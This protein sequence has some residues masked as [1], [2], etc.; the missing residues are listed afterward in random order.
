M[1]PMFRLRRCPWAASVVVLLAGGASAETP[2][3]K[4]NGFEAADKLPQPQP[5][6]ALVTFE[7]EDTDLPEL[8]KV[9]SRMTGK[10]FM[11]AAPKAR[12]FKAS[13]HSP[14]KVTV[15][16]AYQAFLAILQANGL[17]VLNQGKFYKIVDT[18]DVTRQTTAMTRD[19]D[20]IP[21]EERYITH[22]HRLKHGHAEELATGVL[23]KFQSHDGSI[24][25]YG[26][27]NLLII[28]D[29]GANVRRMLRILDELDS[30]GAEDKLYF[31]PIHYV[32]ST[33]LEKKV[34]E[35]IDGRRGGSDPKE[36]PS[37]RLVAL[38]RPN[39]LVIV[40]S[41]ESYRRVLEIVK[42][43]DV[44]E[45]RDIQVHLVLLQHADAKKVVTPLNEALGGG[46]TPAAG[47]TKTSVVEGPVKVS[48][49]ESNNGVLV[50]ASNRDFAAVRDLLS[51]LDQ[52]KRQVYIEAVI[53]DVSTEKGLELGLAFHG[54]TPSPTGGG[55]A[56]FGGFRPM[57]SIGPSTTDLQAFALGLR[58]ASVPVSLPGMSQIPGL[59][60]LVTAA[61]S[62]RGAD[63]LSTP[64]IV[65]SDNT[66]AEIKVQLRTS[67][68]PNAPPAPSFMTGPGG[69]P[70]VAAPAAANYQSIG[71]RI[72][73]TPHINDSSEVRLD[74]DELIS[75]VVSVPDR[76]DT[77]GTVSYVERA[78][79]TTLTVKDEESIVIGGLVRSR[80]A[81][82]E[83]KVPIL[84]D[85]PVLGALFRTTRD[86]MERS[87][88]V[89]V[90]TPHIIR[91]EADR[92]RIFQRKMEERQDMID[93]TAL[94]SGTHYEPPRDYSRTHGLLWDM[95]AEQRTMH[96]QQ[97]AAN[98]KTESQKHEPQ[99]ALSLPEGSS[100][101][102]ATQAPVSTPPKS[103]QPK[104]ERLER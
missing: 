52:P 101:T 77:Y 33:D 67:L 94:F 1:G 81:R 15:T 18:Q 17:T 72:K 46:A 57:N 82:S 80:N 23:G 54:L 55:D 49:D 6:H 84:G 43:I 47:A 10:R 4:E 100:R 66:P 83:T 14:G 53:M 50:T 19:R 90:L 75:D 96:E 42:R 56:L 95:L 28:T 8:V 58:G 3:T 62:V 20:D 12:A 36:S 74:I 89:L 11:V 51:K 70:A 61:A 30:G 29:T 45:T 27:G 63:I 32:S 97:V 34:T 86:Q 2:T 7:L 76:G 91:D 104:V 73:I 41:E 60:A 69:V 39:A 64:H 103:S 48:A 5:P 68:Q 9:V 88:L 26:P 59:G 99:E 102:K 71:P 21:Y 40:G 13:V 79:T 93:R 87:N 22:I 35:I 37:T 85:I 65:A 92:R 25:P 16:E 78:A 31:Q 44:P 98:G 24:V 38:D